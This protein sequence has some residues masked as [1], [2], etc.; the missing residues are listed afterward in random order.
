MSDLRLIVGLASYQNAVISTPKQPYKTFQ[1]F[2]EYSKTNTVNIADMGG[3]SKA[4]QKATE[5]VASDAA[6]L[7]ADA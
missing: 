6:Q 1:D 7:L 4:A 3:I 2:I 5:R